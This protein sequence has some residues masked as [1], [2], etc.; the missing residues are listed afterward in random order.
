MKSIDADAITALTGGACIVTGAVKFATSPSAAFMWGGY[1]DLS[2]DGDTYTGIGDFGTVAPL[3]FETGGVESG[4]QLGLNGVPAEINGLV[5]E[6]Y[7]RG[8]SV[9][10]RRLI[11]DSTGTDL[12]DSSVFFRGR[13]DKVEMRERIGG[14]ASVM[15]DVEGSARGLNRSGARIANLYDQKLISATDTSFERMATAPTATLY[16]MG[17]PPKRVSQVA[18][19]GI[20]GSYFG[21][22]SET[23][24][25]HRQALGLP[26]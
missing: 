8:V 3:S 2:L 1:G 25:K 6:E 10:L 20:L 5:M 16:W 13:I 21:I 19:G 11:F 22:G 14:Q 4:I 23:A 15:I 18:N 17:E 26:F 9:V 7:L 12:L 24:K